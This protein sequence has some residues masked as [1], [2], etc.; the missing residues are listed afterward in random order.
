MLV[1]LFLFFNQP[2]VEFFPEVCGTVQTC[3]M[4]TNTV[5]VENFESF[6]IRTQIIN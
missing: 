6:S 5:F 2:P 1:F 4:I 3:E